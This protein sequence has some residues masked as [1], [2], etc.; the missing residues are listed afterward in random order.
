MSS[1]KQ[2]LA[3]FTI[4]Q[5]EPKYLPLWVKYYSRISANNLY[6]LNHTFKDA[7]QDC[8]DTVQEVP[9]LWENLIPSLQ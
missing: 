4:A 9:K 3:I 6:I 7:L 2:D 1:E 8:K 5:Y